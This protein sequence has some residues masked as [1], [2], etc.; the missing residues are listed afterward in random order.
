[1]GSSPHTRGARTGH[2]ARRQLSGIIPA[3]AGSTR[4]CTPSSPPQMDHPRIRGEHRFRLPDVDPGRGSSPHTRGA[5]LVDLGVIRTVWII[6]AYAGSTISVFPFQFREPDHPRIRGEHLRDAGPG[7]LPAGSS[8]HTR[9]ARRRPLGPPA[10]GTDHPRI[11]GEHQH[12]RVPPQPKHGSSPHTRGARGAGPMVPARRRIIPAYAG[13]TRR[14]RVPSGRREDHPRI[15][16]EHCPF[17]GALLPWTG[18][19]P[20]TRGARRRDDRRPPCGRIIPAYAGSTT[21][22]A[23]SEAFSADHPRIR[24]EHVRV[25]RES[26][27]GDGSSPHTRGAPCSIGVMAPARRIIP[28]YAGSTR[29]MGAVGSILPDHPRIR[30]EHRRANAITSCLSGSSPH[31]RGAPPSSELVIGVCRIIP[32][33]AGSTSTTSSSAVMAG[34]HPRI[35]GEHFTVVCEKASSRGSSPHTRGARAPTGRPPAPGRIIPAYAG[36]TRGAWRR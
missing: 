28:A 29:L 14:H 31:T 24:G 26:D 5:Q 33:Y 27:H 32:A 4:P 35:R 20:H 12:V 30:G 19:S 16:G 25:G 10:P 8:P 17:P 1:M 3:Y 6:P 2:G 13:S 23:Q 15:R 11:R 18:S 21:S 22:D 9:G 34:D 36:S 7:R